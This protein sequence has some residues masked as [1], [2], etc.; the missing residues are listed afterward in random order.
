[1]SLQVPEVGELWRARQYKKRG[2][3]WV[4]I[5]KIVRPGGDRPSVH[6]DRISGPEYQIKLNRTTSYAVL[7]WFLKTYEFAEP[8]I[9]EDGEGEP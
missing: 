1:M 6:F 5:E 2:G 4:R 8:A 7:H 3:N 9:L